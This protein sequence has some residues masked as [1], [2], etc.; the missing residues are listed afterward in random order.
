MGTRLKEKDLRVQSIQHSRGFDTTTDGENRQ[1]PQLDLMMKP[2]V[3]V[4]VRGR[5]RPPPILAHHVLNSTVRLAL[6]CRSQ[7]STW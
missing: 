2:M 7:F 3:G 4:G 5:S 6:L 1:G